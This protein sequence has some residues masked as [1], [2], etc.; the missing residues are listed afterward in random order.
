MPS[1]RLLFLLGAALAA[2]A[3]AAPALA[4]NPFTE[5]VSLTPRDSALAKRVA[6]RADELPHAFARARGSAATI[7]TCAA[8]HPDVSSFTV[9]GRTSRAYEDAKHF[10]TVNSSVRVFASELDARADFLR[11]A[12]MPASRCLTASL[13]AQ[14]MRVTAATFTRDVGVGDSS[15]RYR[16][17]GTVR[18]KDG[19]RVPWH[20]DVLLMRKGR[21]AVTLVTDAPLRSPTG[22]A[23]LLDQMASRV[24]WLPIA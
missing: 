3:A 11:T 6:L 9:T 16:V 5:R 18:A 13:R 22:Q 17:V 24:Q 20:E 14:G 7:S 19:A 21:V 23:G 8:F 1:R 12:T 10:V 2:V 15:V 4:E